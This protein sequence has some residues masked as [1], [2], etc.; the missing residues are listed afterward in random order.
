MNEKVGAISN[1]KLRDSVHDV[2][3]QL[4]KGETIDVESLTNELTSEFK[5]TISPA[6]LDKILDEYIKL[7]RKEKTSISIFNRDDMRWF[8]IREIKGVKEMRNNLHYLKP[9]LTKHKQRLFQEADKK[10]LDDAYK[11][12]MKDLNFSEET[13][14]KSLVL[15][16]AEDSIDIIKYIYSDVVINK[17]Y[18]NTYDNCWKLM[19]LIGKKNGLDRV[20]GW[21]QYA[22]ESVKKE[23]QESGKWGYE[24]T[25]PKS[26]AVKKKTIKKDQP[27]ETENNLRQ[28]DIYM[29]KYHNWESFVSDTKLNE[30]VSLIKEL[31]AKRSTFENI[32]LDEFLSK[33]DQLTF[34]LVKFY[35]VERLDVI[36]FYKNIGLA[37]YI[38]TWKETGKE[39]KINTF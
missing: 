8:G 17:M 13:I 16:K 9:V 33:L 12:G 5:I 7:R 19:M 18:H 38:R 4:K 6:L 26:E 20:R 31:E 2:I 34:I 15:Q 14:K 24:L 23:Y 39:P 28:I 22:P 10:R 36:T 32:Q 11:A 3:V 30:L 25:K 37:G 27:T 1:R 21:W 35:H 29:N